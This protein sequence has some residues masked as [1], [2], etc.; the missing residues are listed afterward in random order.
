MFLPRQAKRRRNPT[1]RP[2]QVEQLEHRWCPSHSLVTS[3]AAL[4]GT[5]SVDWGTLGAPGTFHANP[6]TILSTGN[7]SITVSKPVKGDFEVLEQSP[8]TTPT[9][10]TWNGNFA[11]GD[12]VLYTA[13]GVTR[14]NPIT[15]NFGGTPVAAGGAQIADTN[16]SWTAEVD[17]LDAK[18]RTLASFTEN[19]V[20]TGGR[21]NS[22][23]FIGISSTS[24]D[25]YQIALSIGSITGGDKGAFAINQFDFRAS[26]LAAVAA[27]AVR[28]S[29]SGVNLAPLASSLLG[30]GQSAAVPAHSLLA[31]APRPA[32]GLSSGMVLPAVGTTAAV[33]A[34]AADVVFAASGPA[35]PDDGA[36]LL[37]PLASYSLDTV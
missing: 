20:S 29:A 33:P 23:I 35:N 4:A 17:A 2:L 27:P 34:G 9:V 11:P 31:S 12:M 7:V 16:G 36:G 3:R 26:P 32:P 5:D 21:D 25:I 8:P 22:A 18:G 37:A 19:G 30:T 6:F 13:N 24:A 10:Y 28:Q 1:T 15:L 14:Q